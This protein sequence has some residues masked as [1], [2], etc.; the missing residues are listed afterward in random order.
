VRKFFRPVLALSLILAATAAGAC[1]DKLSAFSRRAQYR[2]AS[3]S[4]QILLFGL[5]GSRAATLAGDPEFQTA[6]KKSGHKLRV[7][8]SAERLS[9]ELAS[10]SFDVVLA[11]AD[12][13]AKVEDQM[14]SHSS[15]AVFV[16]VIDAPSKADLRA[17]QRHYAVVVTS[18][19][20]TGHYIDALDDAVD[21]H[22]Q[23]KQPTKMA[24]K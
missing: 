4:G 19:A 14:Q 8:D 12:S 7:V 2:N 23:R 6:V 16:P 3:Q 1:G 10:G 17:M 18:H 24:R 22:A 11:D 13:A 5:P 15:S 21:L 9:S 20:K